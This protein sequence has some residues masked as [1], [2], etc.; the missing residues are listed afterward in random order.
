MFISPAFAQGATDAAAG[1]SFI[2]QLVPFIAIIAIMYFLVI[3]P[4]QQR[5]KAHQ[6]LIAAV[7]RGDVVVT[8]GGIIGKV[9]KVLENDEVMV[10]IADDVRVR[11][12]KSTIADIRSK[13][14]PVDGKAA[15]DEK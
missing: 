4:Q 13:T 15:N 2:I 14:E 3:R 6:A 5:L 11:V 8:S 7:K 12:L 10:E 1:T 9:V